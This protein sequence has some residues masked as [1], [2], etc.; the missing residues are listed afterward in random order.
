MVIV[1][2][3]DVFSLCEHHMVPF[4]G[5]VK[6]MDTHTLGASKTGVLTGYT[7]KKGQSGFGLTNF[8]CWP[9]AFRFI[10]AISPRTARLSA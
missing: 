9:T 6:S 2:N 4:T 8:H 3:I 1:K 5:K 10:S 7:G